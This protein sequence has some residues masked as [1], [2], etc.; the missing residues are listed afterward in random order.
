MSSLEIS[1]VHSGSELTKI[2]E[3]PV[4]TADEAV[5]RMSAVSKALQEYAPELPI[6][7]LSGKDNYT[8]ILSFSLPIGFMVGIM[9]NSIIG[10]VVGAIL[11]TVFIRSVMNPI[12]LKGKTKSKLRR[13]LL[14]MALS[15][16]TK[17]DISKHC[18]EVDDYND[19]VILYKVLVAQVME[20]LE[21][22]GT[23]EQ[24]RV[25]LSGGRRYEL[26]PMGQIQK[27]R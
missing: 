23:M 6:I 20:Q 27:S 4:S 8:S 2:M 11:P 9:S 10:A 17:K 15:E 25:I 18:K 21:K 14:D 1:D 22:D 3:K 12:L 19:E 13:F 26:S 16:K 7:H 24:T 5:A